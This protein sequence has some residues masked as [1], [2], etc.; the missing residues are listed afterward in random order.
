[1]AYKRIQFTTTPPV[2]LG[3]R[4]TSSDSS[5]AGDYLKTAQKNCGYAVY[6]CSAKGMYL[7]T[8][9]AE[10]DYGMGNFWALNS[11]VVSQ[12]GEMDYDS[13]Q[14]QQSVYAMHTT[15]D[16]DSRDMDTWEIS[17]DFTNPNSSFLTTTWT[18]TSG[19]VSITASDI[20]QVP[21]P[22]LDEFHV[23]WSGRAN[24]LSTAMDIPRDGLAFDVQFTHEVSKAATGQSLTIDTELKDD[25][26]TIWKTVGGL[27]CLQS[28]YGRDGGRGGV[29]FSDAA[30]N[31]G[32]K[33]LTVSSWIYLIVNSG[34]ERG[35]WFQIG[36]PNNEQLEFGIDGDSY[37]DG[38]PSLSVQG[39]TPGGQIESNKWYHVVYVFT[40][41]SA[42]A[43]LNGNF[44]GSC[45]CDRNVVKSGTAYVCRDGSGAGRFG[46]C[47]AGIRVYNRILSDSEI[48]CLFNEH[49]NVVG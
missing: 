25:D 41:Y 7:F 13:Y 8:G 16:E 32:R 15:S 42:I 27:P 47:I 36:T 6:Y 44:T 45:S 14:F 34:Y 10:S 12:L 20:V 29:Y 46:G 31:S 38:K 2:V 22:L 1:M 4:L 19:S 9:S 17:E 18:T 37:Y 33:S 11:T 40:G 5:I 30:F 23:D 24:R 21:L 43:Y 35:V 49:I 26:V 3:I 28:Y 48:K 39:Q